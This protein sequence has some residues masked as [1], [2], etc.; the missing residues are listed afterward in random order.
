[1]KTVKVYCRAVF[2][3][4]STNFMRNMKHCNCHPNPSFSLIFLELVLEIQIEPVAFRLPHLDTP[5]KIRHTPK[6]SLVQLPD[7]KLHKL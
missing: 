5:P 6:D 7:K 2:A 1:M 3:L 4:H